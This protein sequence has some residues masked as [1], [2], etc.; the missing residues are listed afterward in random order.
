MA[1][2]DTWPA[3]YD[4]DENSDIFTLKTMARKDRQRAEELAS[5]PLASLAP[6]R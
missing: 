6:L 5:E 4:T 3:E 1:G 2:Q